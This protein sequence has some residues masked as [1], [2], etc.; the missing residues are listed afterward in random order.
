MDLSNTLASIGAGVLEARK[1][2]GVEGITAA[3]GMEYCKKCGEPLML[4]LHF[5]GAIAETLGAVR[6]VPRNC[7]CMKEMFALEDEVREQQKRAEEIKRKRLH[8]LT[9][10]K[11]RKSTFEKDDGR[12]P[13]IRKTC[14]RYVAK[15]KEMIAGNLGLAFIGSNGGGKTFWASC[16][17]NGL[18]EAG[19]TVLMTTLTKLIQEMNADYGENRDAI[20]RKIKTVDFLILDDYGAERGT[21]FSLEQAFEV[22]DT[23]YGAEKPLIIT[24]NLTEEILKNPPSINY[25]R[26]YSR[27]IEM[28]PALIKVEG[29]RR[30][31]IAAEKRKLLA[32]LMRGE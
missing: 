21:E 9:S 23:R 32:D 29:E 16:I 8:C 2:A 6:Y 27:V 24:A 26:S 14:E 13:A 25:A 20:L 5:S 28:C 18:I 30:K 19:A 7:L 22:L 15:R 31:E 12:A 1:R 10:E 4:P 17:A 11:Y 3:D